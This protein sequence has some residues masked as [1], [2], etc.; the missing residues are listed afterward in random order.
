MNLKNGSKVVPSLCVLSNL[1]LIS[2]LSASKVASFCFPPGH[3]SLLISII[4]WRQLFNE[5]KEW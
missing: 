4:E 2:A 3:K 5:P 1:F